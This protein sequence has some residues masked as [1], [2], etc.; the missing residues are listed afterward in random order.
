MDIETLLYISAALAFG[1]LVL[2]YGYA[3]KITTGLVS[4]HPVCVSNTTEI[5]MC[6]MI[7]GFSKMMKEIK[8]EEELTVRIFL[9]R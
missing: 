2:L 6:F 1:S 7:S 5:I 8:L 9:F 3:S 4:F